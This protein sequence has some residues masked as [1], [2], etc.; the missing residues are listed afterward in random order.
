L[1]KSVVHTAEFILRLVK[2][3]LLGRAFDFIDATADA[4]TREHITICEIPAPPFG[5]EPRA[6]YFLRRF[7]ELGLEAVHQD[8]EGNVIGLR[9]GRSRQPTIVISAHLDTVFSGNLDIRV[10]RRNGRL[11]AP[12]ISDNASGLAALLALINVVQ[13]VDIPTVGTL[14]FLGTVGEEGEGNLRGVRHFFVNEGWADKVS[15][16]IS[17]DG[18]GVERIVHQALGSRRY[19]ITVTGPGGHSWGDFGIV[20][21]IHP[22]A[23]VITQLIEYPLPRRPRTSLSVGRISGGQSVNAIPQTAWMDVDIRSTS[24]KEIDRI[25][26][27]LGAVVEDA[28]GEE[29]LRRASSGTQLGFGS[30]RLGERPTGQTALDSEIVRVAVEASRVF[31]IDP[32]LECASTDSNIPISLGIPA[33]TIGAGGT[34]GSPHTLDEWYDATHRELGIKRA[35]LIVLA[36]AGVLCI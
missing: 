6:Q 26:A 25:E 23:R 28:V 12:G 36:L 15:G 13:Q 21:P 7:R 11:Y 3:P 5:E 20:N 14:I 16:F 4:T 33:I 2:S 1:E 24:L 18:H 29:N 8:A 9:R 22:L 27:Y 17:F 31:D 30:E 34:A 32:Q 19:R 10:R 35:L